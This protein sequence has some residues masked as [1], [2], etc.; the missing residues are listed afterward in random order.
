MHSTPT[1]R[2]HEGEATISDRSGRRYLASTI[3][4]DERSVTFTGR[5][6]HNTLLGEH[7]YPEKTRTM[8]LSAVRIEWLDEDARVAV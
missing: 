6:L 5:P 7:V 2:H 1:S 8:P 3:S 4:L